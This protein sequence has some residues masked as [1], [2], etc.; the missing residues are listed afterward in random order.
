MQTDGGGGNYNQVT[1]THKFSPFCNFKFTSCN[2][3]EEQDQHNRKINQGK[4]YRNGCNTTGK[5]QHIALPPFVSSLFFRWGLE[6]LRGRLSL[7][8]WFKSTGLYKQK[9]TKLLWRCTVRCWGGTLPC[10]AAS[11]WSPASWSPFED[12]AATSP[13]AN[14]TQDS[15]RVSFPLFY[16]RDWILGFGG[17]TNNNLETKKYGIMITFF[18]FDLKLPKLA[19]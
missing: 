6:A 11:S 19:Q 3:R 7:R 10:A 16:H 18:Y 14:E 5:T 15:P 1:R 8:G 13:T 12:C 17:R 2:Y 9:S 4:V